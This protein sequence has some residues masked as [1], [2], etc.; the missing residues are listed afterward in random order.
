MKYNKKAQSL[1]SSFSTG[2]FSNQHIL[3]E[4]ILVSSMDLACAYHVAQ[5][6]IYPYLGGAE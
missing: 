3:D 1:K 4:E 6:K 2:L 5:N